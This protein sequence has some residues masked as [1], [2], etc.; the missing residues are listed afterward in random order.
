LNSLTDSSSDDEV[1]MQPAGAVSDEVIGRETAAAAILEIGPG[2]DDPLRLVPL[3]ELIAQ[4]LDHL[5]TEARDCGLPGDFAR[6]DE[7]SRSVHC[8]FVVLREH[9]VERG[10]AAL[11]DQDIVVMRDRRKTTPENLSVAAVQR[12][13]APNAAPIAG[14]QSSWPVEAA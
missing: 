13:G 10:G 4:L 8:S 12:D 14:L 7:V 11:F 3:L 1:D 5:W 9:A 6:L 2:E